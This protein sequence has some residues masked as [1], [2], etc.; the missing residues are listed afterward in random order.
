MIADTK[1]P[2]LAGAISGGFLRIILAAMVRH[3]CPK[4]ADQPSQNALHLSV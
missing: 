1:M 4:L 3:D 2:P